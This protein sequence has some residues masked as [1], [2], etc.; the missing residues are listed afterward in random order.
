MY[1]F[2]FHDFSEKTCNTEDFI[3]FLTQLSKKNLKQKNTY[4]A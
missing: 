4:P 3:W 1:D 2:M